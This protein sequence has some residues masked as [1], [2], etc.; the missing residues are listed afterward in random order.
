MNTKIHLRL[1]ILVVSPLFATSALALPEEQIPVD[2]SVFDDS[3][4]S[5]PSVDYTPDLPYNT[6]DI[7]SDVPSSTIPQGG[8]E[9]NP[10]N[11]SDPGSFILDPLLKNDKNGNLTEIYNI[12][13]KAAPILEALGGFIKK[14]LGFDVVPWLEYSDFLIGR[15]KQGQLLEQS[16]ISVAGIPISDL[17][18]P[19]GEVDP[20]LVEEQAIEEFKATQKGEPT[21]LDI[22]SDVIEKHLVGLSLTRANLKKQQIVLGKSGQLFAKDSL[23]MV[24]KLV[25][26]AGDLSDLAGS[27]K[28][29]QDV[30]KDISKSF[31]NQALLDQAAY[32]EAQQG[33]MAMERQND[34]ALKILEEQQQEKWGKHVDETF[35]DASLIQ[36]SAFAI[37]LARR[38]IP[39]KVQ[40][41][42]TIAQK[43]PATSFVETSNPFLQ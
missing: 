15:D 27:R 34:T 30:N 41:E 39:G 9:D 43:S 20:A 1:A 22:P 6:G 42:G 5:S 4:T 19:N 35:E 10:V 17:L 28:S 16:E 11:P 13:N 8:F 29:T 36:S 2:Y 25:K 21:L 12:Y 38:E 24:N 31:A 18:G 33:R 26:N 40:P 37:G 7:P 14:N 32:V 3:S 23:Q